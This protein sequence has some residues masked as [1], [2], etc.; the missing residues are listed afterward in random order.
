MP[1]LRIE[2][3]VKADSIKNMGE[4]LKKYSKLV[5]DHLN[6]NELYVMVVIVPDQAI[7]MAGTCDP[8]AN[9][10]LNSIGGIGSEKNNDFAKT[11]HA[12]L[13]VDMG[14]PPNRCYIQFNDLDP[15]NVGFDGSTFG[16]K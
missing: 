9:V 1:C 8:C 5:S 10:M 15:A 4:L 3:N 6:K 14:V 16:G 11:F 12:L 7:A 13:E 2:T